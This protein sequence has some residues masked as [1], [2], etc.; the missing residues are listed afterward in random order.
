MRVVGFRT[1]DGLIHAAIVDSAGNVEPLCI[2][3]AQAEDIVQ[4]RLT[5]PD[6]RRASRELRAKL[7]GVL[8]RRSF[9]A[10]AHRR[11]SV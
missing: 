6:C 8:A 7:E 5:C 1:V 11:L 4:E 2:G 3:Y 10:A 9:R